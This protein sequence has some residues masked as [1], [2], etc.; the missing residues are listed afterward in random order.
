MTFLNT[1]QYRQGAN[2]GEAPESDNKKTGVG[3]VWR[4]RQIRGGATPPAK[5]AL[6]SK[7]EAKTNHR[8]YQRAATGIGDKHIA[9]MPGGVV[10]P[11]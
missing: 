3:C 10:D 7:G 6:A 1:V 4:D 11:P 9:S 5:P 2:K 8:K